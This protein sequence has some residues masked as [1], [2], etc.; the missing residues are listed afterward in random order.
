MKKILL[1]MIAIVCVMLLVACG[2]DTGPSDADP[3]GNGTCNH[4]WES[5]VA[6]EYIK[7]P[8][9]CMSAAN[10][11]QK[12]KLCGEKGG[13]PFT[14]GAAQDHSY[15]DVVDSKYL[16]SAPTCSKLGVYHKSCVYC[17]KVG[18]DTFEG[19]TLAPH[20]KTQAANTNTF[21]EKSTCD[22]GNLYY[23]SCS[24]CDYLYDEVYEFGPKRNH[25]DSHGDYICDLCEATMKV[26][27][28]DPSVDKITDK[29]EFGKN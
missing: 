12:C 9:T 5:V 4:E 22:H 29:H 26:W 11:Y 10:Y 1:L 7:D 16:V 24:N 15:G 18:T 17:G 25:Y 19:G 2:K 20:N 8:A 6:D 14:S 3:N 13:V 27:T 21:A 28:G 23:Y